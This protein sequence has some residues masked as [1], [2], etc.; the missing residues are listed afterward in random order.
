MKLSDQ[1]RQQMAAVVADAKAIQ[2]AASKEGRELTDEEAQTIDA[3]LADVDA[4]KEQIADAE[5]KEKA[6]FE[7]AR[8]LEAEAAAL[9]KPQPKRTASNPQ[10]P[11]GPRIEMGKMGIEEDPK[12]GWQTPRAF[13]NDVITKGRGGRVANEDGL[14]FLAAAGSDEQSTFADPYGGFLVPEAF[15]PSL[16]ML[17]P[18]VDPMEGAT[19]R[20]PMSAPTVRINA[21]VDKNHATSVSGG[22]TVSRRAEADTAG[23]SRM[24]FEQIN[25]QATS[26]FGVS[27]ATEEILTD[28]PISFAALLDAGFRDQFAFH[29]I[30]ERLNGTGVGEYMGI[31]SSPA[32]VS[33]NKE[34]GQAADTIV[35]ENIIKMRA[36][37]WM[38]SRA[39]WMANHDTLPQLMLLNQSVG[40]GGMPVWQPSAREDHPDTLLGRPLFFTEHCET[41]GDAGD[42]LLLTLSEYLEGI[43][44]PL[45]SAESIHVRF[46]NHERTFKFWVRNAGAP[47]WRAA[48]TPRKSSDTLSPFVR[49]AARA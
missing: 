32:L 49:L 30:G 1:L 6:R 9:A 46:L 29:L 25:L 28:S 22:L 24:E 31:N 8:R 42:I 7:Q 43:Y 45:Q 5:A 34:T 48:L 27:Y 18:E 19:T 4:Y 21:R 38:Y 36:R 17:E 40:T 39:I 16:F 3:K 41:L 15:T 2:A 44:Q 35:Y 47:W 12:R 10:L 14:R 20:I 23:S 37:S 33:I 13:L 11:N 26:L